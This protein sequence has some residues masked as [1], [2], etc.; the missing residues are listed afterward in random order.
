MRDLLVEDGELKYWEDFL[1]PDAAAE[2]FLRLRTELSWESEQYKIYGK[3]VTAPRLVCWYGDSGANYRYSG[4]DHFPKPWIPA[5][6]E[7]KQKIESNIPA[8]FNSMLGN[9]YRD[10][11]DSMGWHA[12][13]E[14]ELGLSPL[15]ASLSLGAVRMFKIRHNRTKRILDIPLSSGS[16][17][18]MA[19]DF[20]HHWRHS[21]PKTKI[22][23]GERINLT[24]R[25]IISDARVLK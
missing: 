5:L 23:T 25:T 9:L 11:N 24:F 10:G 19:G 13:K 16:L 18:I 8:T 12:D 22:I 6:I 21:V 14:R 2:L 17:L 20:Q 7:I 1:P 15:I 4:I 3:W